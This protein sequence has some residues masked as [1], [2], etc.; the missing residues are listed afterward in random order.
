VGTVVIAA[1][2]TRHEYLNHVMT[3]RSLTWGCM[4]PLP[5]LRVYVSTDKKPDFIAEQCGFCSS[6]ILVPT[7]DSPLQSTVK[8]AQNGTRLFRYFFSPQFSQVSVLQMV[9]F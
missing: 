7:E 1:V 9:V 8:P 2:I 3:L 4:E 5:V 6:S